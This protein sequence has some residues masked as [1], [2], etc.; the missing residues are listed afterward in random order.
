M[1]LN[2]PYETEIGGITVQDAERN[3]SLL[4]IHNTSEVM[5]SVLSEKAVPMQVED[6]ILQAQQALHTHEE[7]NEHMKIRHAFRL[8]TADSTIAIRV[9]EVQSEIRAIEEASFSISDERLIYSGKLGAQISK[10]GMF[11]FDIILPD[12]F[13]VDSLHCIQMSHWDDEVVNGQRLV[14]V[15]LKNKTAF[16]YSLAN[17]V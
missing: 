5:L 15:F 17:F 2:L 3:R 11:A 12:G 7:M 8:D 13:D 4:G 10:S 14:H 16:L 6:F 1:S 9:Q